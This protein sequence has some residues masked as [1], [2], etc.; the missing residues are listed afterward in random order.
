[1]TPR[2]I[3][4]DAILESLR[5]TTIVTLDDEPGVRIELFMECDD[6]VEANGIAEYWGHDGKG[7]RWRVHV[8]LGDRRIY[9]VDE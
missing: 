7:D 4:K 9:E 2:E 5:Y 8:R 6:D 3:A 1:M